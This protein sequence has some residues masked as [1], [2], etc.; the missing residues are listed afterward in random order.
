M[1]K[2]TGP[3]YSMG[4]SGKIANAMVFFPWKGVNVVR[5]WLKPS[6][7]KTASQ[8]DARM[9]LGGAGRAAALA[10]KN[11]DYVGQLN[12]LGLV[13]GGQ[14]KQSY[15]V[16]KIVDLFGTDIATFESNYDAYDGHSNQAVFD[17]AAST[18][19]LNTVDVSY[20]TGSKAFTGGLMLYLLA[21][22]GITLGFSGAPYATA[23]ASWDTTQVNALVVDLV[24]E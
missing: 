23:L 11:N 19:S 2:V 21:K 7:P 20:K 16:K 4:A 14:T 5:Q 12:T 6:N 18:L 1:A 24:G 13:P 10:D 9:I 3:L 22:L 15:I 8:G 17:S